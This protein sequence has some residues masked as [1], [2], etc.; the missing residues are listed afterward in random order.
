M[1]YIPIHTQPFYR[2]RGFR[3]GQFPAAE[4][5]YAGAISIPLY[6]NLTEVQQDHV[7]KQLKKALLA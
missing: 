3:P 4:A 7:V 6:P 2:A 1:H 5:Y